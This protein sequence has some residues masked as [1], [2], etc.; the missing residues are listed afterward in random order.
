[1][2][3]LSTRSDRPLAGEIAV[4]G[5]K[6]LSHRAVLFAA[7]AEGTSRLAAVLDSE[8]VRA[9]IAAVRAL[10]ANVDITAAGDRGLEL[11]V[12]GWGAE[13]PRTPDV[14]I[15]CGN[16]GTTARLLLGIL[17]GWASEVTLVGDESLSKRPMGRVTDP[18]ARMGASFESPTGTLPVT[19]RGGGLKGIDYVTPVASAQVKSAIL[20]AGVQASG[21][22]TVREPASSRDHTELLLPAFGVPV[23]RDSAARAAWVDGPATVRASDITVP[24]DPSSAA[25]IVVAGLLVPGSR[26]TVSGVGLNPTRIAYLDVLDRM[27][28]DIRIQPTEAAGAEPTG[29]V[30][31]GYTPELRAV[32]VRAAEVPALVDEIPVLALLATQAAGETRFED[33][34]ELRVKESD[35]LAAVIEA[36]T[37][38]GASAR[39]EGDTL[40]VQG[41]SE[42]RGTGLDSHGDHRLAMTWAL[43]GL[44]ADGPVTVSGFEAVDVSYPSFSA[45][46]AALSANS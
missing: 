27:G 20:L 13:G 6:S 35:R 15:D 19:L 1:M 22:T 46:L 18:L 29:T 42:L 10:G 44:A 2:Q 11:T 43:A 31:V 16:S 41:P 36:L 8:D 12:T 30:H 5:D 7:M 45:D 39:A 32:V 14:P 26:I 3:Y 4:P 9:S 40:V 28:A 34:G 21:R 24:G 25:F 37:L 23:G 38:L 33:V 17:A